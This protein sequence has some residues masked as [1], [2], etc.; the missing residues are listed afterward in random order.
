MK[1]FVLALAVVACAALSALA[2]P[3]IVVTEMKVQPG[4]MYRIP[5]KLKSEKDELG[6]TKNFT[7]EQ[8]FFG[9]M[10]GPK[11]A[12][13]FV[14][15]AP[16]IK[17]D[18]DGKDIPPAKTTFFVSWWVVGES[19]GTTTTLVLDYEPAPKPAPNPG[20]QPG[21]QPN[22]Q[23]EPKPTPVVPAGKRFIL[24]IEETGDAVASRG[25]IFAD[26]ALS[27]RTKEQGH[28]WRVVDKDNKTA[29]GST[30][31][32]LEPY[33]KEAAGKKLPR[34]YVVAPDG[35]PTYVGDAPNDP[36]TVAGQMLDII[37]KA[38]G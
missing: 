37:K 3:P 16:A 31:A 26:P 8:A 19:E 38:G 5:V 34:M 6:Q 21:P 12:R 4:Q 32:D 36:A 7:D 14:F 11:G 25:I 30:P 22:P 28:K 35:T 20:P 17:K 2:D 23:P 29:T 33:F 13:H 18:K 15:Q 24:I 1:R 9:E 10:F 27:A